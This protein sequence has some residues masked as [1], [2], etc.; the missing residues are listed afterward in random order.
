MA[1]QFEEVLL[2]HLEP[3]PEGT[4][5]PQ[6]GYVDSPSTHGVRE[7][8]IF[9]IQEVMAQAGRVEPERRVSWRYAR[10]TNIE[11]TADVA[12]V[13]VHFEAAWRTQEVED[14][15][16]FT[17]ICSTLGKT[18][19]ASTTGYLFRG[20]ACSCWRLSP[21]LLRDLPKDITS[22]G[23]LEIE[24]R[25]LREF[26]SQAHLHLPTSVLPANDDVVDSWTLMQQHGAPTRLLDWTKSPYV[27]AYFAV[28]EH[29]NQDGA[30]WV[31]FV[32]GMREFMARR[33]GEKDICKVRG[34]YIT[35]RAAHEQLFAVE[36]RTKSD[37]MLVQ[38]GGFTICTQVLADHERTIG[39]CYPGPSPRKP[40]KL[41]IRHE[42]KSDFLKQLRAMNVTG[43]SL[44]PG[45][46]GIGRSVKELV[47]LDGRTYA[48]PPFE[49]P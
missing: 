1:E 28:A 37:R 22:E 38:Q 45:V 6:R 11:G 18:G 43:S 32:D 5:E 42:L 15:E 19:L 25:A 48:P 7:G 20:Q 34:S 26:M 44:F 16:D 9:D 13:R 3:P 2:V 41:T 4:S 31:F 35:H 21:S 49:V 10:V 40:L 17:K 27:A 24:R 23:A 39:A 14:W 12:C 30:I 33:F 8:V 47:L 29:W 46:D 36:R